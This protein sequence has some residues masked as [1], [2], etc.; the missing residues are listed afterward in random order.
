MENII[1]RQVTI[2]FD[3][4]HLINSPVLGEVT[5]EMLKEHIQT[6]FASVCVDV[7]IVEAEGDFFSITNPDVEIGEENI[8]TD[9]ESI[10]ADLEREGIPLSY[11]PYE[12]R[13]R[14]LEN[15]GIPRSDAQGIAESEGLHPLMRKP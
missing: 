14:E 9:D 7:P 3:L 2:T 10:V 5:E 1:N 4:K 15:K 13:C 12:K 8:P 6:Y 11:L